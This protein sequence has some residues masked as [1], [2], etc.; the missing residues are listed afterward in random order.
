MNEDIP[1]PFG[2]PAVSRLQPAMTA[3]KPGHHIP[4]KSEMARLHPT[5]PVFP[6]SAKVGNGANPVIRRGAI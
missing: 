5:Q 6:P 3:F 2:L 1:L 4:G